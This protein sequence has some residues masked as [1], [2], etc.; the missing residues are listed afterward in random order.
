MTERPVR[1]RSGAVLLQALRRG[2][3]PR[4]T[5]GRA[6]QEP[7][8]AAS[9]LTTVYMTEFEPL[10]RYL[11]GRSPQSVRPL[12][13]QF[14][15]LRGDLT[16]GL[17]GEKLAG[18]LDE[19]LRRGRSPDRPARS[20]AGGDVRAGVRRVAGHDRPRRGRGHPGPGHAARPGRQG[21]AG[22]HA[23][24]STNTADHERQPKAG[25]AGDLVGRGAGR[26]RQPGDR[27]RL[28]PAVVLGAGAGREI[29]EGLVMLVAAGVLFYVSYWLV[30]QAEAKR[31]MDFLKQQARRG[32]EWGGRGTLAVTAFLAVYREGAETSLMYQA[33][34]GSQ[35]QTRP[36]L[37]G[38][39]AGLRRRAGDPGRI[40][41]L[42]RATSVRLPLRAVLQVQRAVPLRAGHRLRRQRRLRAPECRH[43]D[44]DPP[45]LDGQR[46]PVGGSLSQSPGGLG[47]RVPGRRRPAGMG[48]DA[49]S[50]ARRPQEL[51]A[52]SGRAGTGAT[53]AVGRRHISDRRGEKETDDA[54]TLE[55]VRIVVLLILGGVVLILALNLNLKGWNAQLPRSPDIAPLDAGAPSTASARAMRRSP[56]RQPASAST[57]SA[58]RS[59]RTRC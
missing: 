15:A 56:G 17:K 32:L 6:R 26:H 40:A 58:T 44:H 41:V 2:F 19:L 57:R 53:H 10:E 30:S 27:G 35:G 55:R 3:A 51:T 12:E 7:D 33:L 24:E 18:R 39:A 31:W 4:A 50:R 28:E 9:E 25:D 20:P 14:N 8:E 37:L 5:G 43:P 52:G 16:A 23:D 54:S 29:L 22:G 49:R 45:G 48:R 1:G 36:G 59:R 21:R 42:V 11:F 46:V 38:L 34:L 47:A 13:V